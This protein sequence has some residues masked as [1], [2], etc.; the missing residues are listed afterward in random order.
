MKVLHITNN[1]PTTKY[2][3][4]GIF[5][6]EQIDSLSFEGVENEV[7][8]INGR[9][10]GK[11]AYFN[12]L[13]ALRGKLRNDDYDILHCHHV[14]SAVLLL[15]TFRFYKSKR[16]VSYQNPPEK[17]GGIILFKIIKLFFNGVILKNA[18]SNN[19]KIFYLPNGTNID[20]FKNYSKE[21]S[22]RKL[23]LDENKN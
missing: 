2:P 7:F 12:G 9:E 20:F 17:E 16:I 14:F 5:V 8:F 3:I 23:N 1:Y 15:F 10:I 21:E 19:N 11:N 18:K 13:R 6:K 4:F 22:K